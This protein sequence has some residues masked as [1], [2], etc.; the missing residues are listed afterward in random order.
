MRWE[1]ERYV[2]L[3]TRDTPEFLAMSWQARGLFA[4]ILRKVDRAGVLAVGRLGLKGVAVAVG[5]PWVEVEGPLA[6]L[7]DDGCVFF[8][9][10]QNRIGIPNFLEAQE[11][12]QSD[13]A[14]ARA[15]RERAAALLGSSQAAA[16]AARQAEAEVTIRDD[17]SSRNVTVPSQNVTKSHAPSRGVTPCH[18][19]SLCAVPSHAVPGESAP[20]TGAPT[21]ER[22]DHDERESEPERE[23]AKTAK[24]TKTASARGTRLSPDWEPRTEDLERFRTRERVDASRCVERFK[25][26]FLTVTG[27]NATKLDWDRAFVNWVLRDLDDGKLPKLA[28][29][30]PLLRLPNRA[31]LLAHDLAN[32]PDM[33]GF[34]LGA[35]K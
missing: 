5:A 27:R 34:S 35:T 32:A 29:E 13:K 14:R 22:I 31:E 30:L 24:T 11:S 18:T 15:S 33:T 19:P 8:D 3:Y 21:H 1:D 28:E 20:E 6:E 23:P 12:P 16:V 2:R 9:P 10:S 17:I 26:Y 25:N 4:L 7:L